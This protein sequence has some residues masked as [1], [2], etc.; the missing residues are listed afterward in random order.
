MAK[1]KNNSKEYIRYWAEG[2]SIR[3]CVAD[4][5]TTV[6]DILHRDYRNLK[7]SDFDDIYLCAGLRRRDRDGRRECEIR[8]L[9][10]VVRHRRRRTRSG[11]DH[12]RGARH[13]EEK[14]RINPN[15]ASE[16]RAQGV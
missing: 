8:Q 7:C 12:R 5:I 9:R 3:P 10:H 2:C 6:S 11:G 14:E 16:K 15:R 4:Y 13:L 1:R